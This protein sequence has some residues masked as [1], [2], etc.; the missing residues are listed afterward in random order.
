MPP[1]RLLH[2]LRKFR[3]GAGLSQRD[4]ARLLGCDTQDRV[5]RYERYATVPSLTT[6]IA[7]EI[8]FGA[9]FRDLL[10]GLY[11]EVGQTVGIRAAALLPKLAS[12]VRRRLAA[13]REVVK[14]LTVL[15]KTHHR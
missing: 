11:A 3:K 10:P 7:Y 5:S 8:I 2:H 1:T 9:P 13:K 6:A 14:A 12:P 15:K 4:M